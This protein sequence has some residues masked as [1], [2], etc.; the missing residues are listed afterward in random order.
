MTATARSVQLRAV[1]QEIANALPT[2]VEEVVL[3]GSVSRNVADDVSDI[4]MLNVTR[5]ELDLTSCCSL[6]AACGV[7][8]LG[9]WGPRGTPTKR[10]SGYRDGVP[11]EL[12][13]WSHAHAETEIDAVFAGERSVTADALA[14][15]VAL[16]TSG[17]LAQW[18]ER[19]RD[20]P[21]DLAAAW[22]EDAALTWGGFAP[23]GLLT[24]LRPGDRLALLERMVDDAARV[25]RIV[26]ALN[27]VWQPTHKRL[28]DRAATLTHKP[29][30]LAERIAEALTAPDPRRAVLVLTELQA[31]TVAL[32]PD[33]PNVER[34]RKW[35]ADA[36]E[37]LVRQKPP[38]AGS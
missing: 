28:A 11:V 17:L 3:T 1:A 25:V 31:E 34:A 8:D 27:R 24:L 29:E 12:I 4:E 16:R 9:T 23:A 6:A 26:F 30:R 10:V 7:T 21:D 37:I 2:T 38:P 22:I 35:L 5:G 20:Y 32:A 13:W 36:H 19:L 18:Q 15:G 33:G 14:N